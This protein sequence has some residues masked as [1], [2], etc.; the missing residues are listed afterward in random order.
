LK[1]PSAPSV[2]LLTPP[3]RTPC[4]FQWMAVSIC[5]CIWQALPEALKWLLSGSYQKALRGIHKCGWV[6]CLDMEWIPRW[7]SL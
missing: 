2:F 6:W 3:L 4:L 1:I 7:G 5:R